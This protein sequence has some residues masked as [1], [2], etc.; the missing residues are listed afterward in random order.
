MRQRILRGHYTAPEPEINVTPLVDVVLVLLIIFMVVVPQM[1]AQLAVELPRVQH[2]DPE[3][4]Q[5]L[6]PWPVTVL[7]SGEIYVAD[8]RV[9]I[10]E[11]RDVLFGLR[12][13][14]PARRVVLRA[15][16]GLEWAR[17]R[18]V[19]GELQDA[20]FAGASLLVNQRRPDATGGNAEG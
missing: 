1:Q 9:E 4:K 20:G 3:Q 15:D 16:A 14:D 5:A 2:A 6:D 11:L 8:R 12:Q 7:R 17:V 19:L 10:A 18:S 13:S